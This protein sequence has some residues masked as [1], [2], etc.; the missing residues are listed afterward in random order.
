MNKSFLICISKK[1]DWAWAY[2]QVISSNIISNSYFLIT[3]EKN[4]SKLTNWLGDLN[5]KKT[6]MFTFHR[7]LRVSMWSSHMVHWFQ[8][9]SL[10]Y[11]I[12]C[13]RVLRLLYAILYF[14]HY[15]FRPQS[16][17]TYVLNF[18]HVLIS[19]QQ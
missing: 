14:N 7:Y 17:F 9:F 11:L 15:L 6:N 10:C 16:H 12:Y 8:F 19:M 18:V 5:K 2:S 3:H 4:L 1:T 13:A